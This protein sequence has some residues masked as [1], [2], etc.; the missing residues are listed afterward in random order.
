MTADEPICSARD[1]R[2]P[3]IW[4]LAW[5]NPK[6]HEADRRKTWAACDDHREHLSDFLRLRGFLREVVR[7]DEWEPAEPGG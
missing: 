1:C 2:A 5:N 7:L 4:V 6:L 3:A